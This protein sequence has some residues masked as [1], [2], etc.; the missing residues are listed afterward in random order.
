MSLRYIDPSYTRRWCMDCHRRMLVDARRCMLY[1]RNRHTRTHP[2]CRHYH[3]RNTNRPGIQPP[4]SNLKMSKSHT[5]RNRLLRRRAKS[6]FSPNSTVRCSYIRPSSRYLHN[7]R[8]RVNRSRRLTP[9]RRNNYLRNKA[10]SANKQAC[11]HRRHCRMSH[12]YKGLRR[13]N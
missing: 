13:H 2:A 11:R 9:E 7:I 4:N 3:P 12:W 10:H 8:V 5:R 6:I 1:T